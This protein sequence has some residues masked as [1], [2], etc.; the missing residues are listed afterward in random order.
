MVLTKLLRSSQLNNLV[1]FHNPVI[2]RHI[3][4]STQSIT[5]NNVTSTYSTEQTKTNLSQLFSDKTQTSSTRQIKT[6]QRVVYKE[7]SPSVIE[8]AKYLYDKGYFESD[9]SVFPSKVFD[10]ACLRN[11]YGLNFLRHAAEK[12]GCD[13]QEI[14]KW[15]SG[16]ELKKVALFGCPSLSKKAV[17][18]AKTLRTFF[19]I[20]ENT[21]ISTFIRL[22]SGLQQLCSETILQVRESECME[23]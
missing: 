3:S 12:F 18:S 11:V 22:S 7:L 9:S 8:F 5:T 17:F 21:L 1:H 2:N 23:Q 14:A 4:L 16:S 15:L 20:Q 19:K 10:D 6:D 13:N